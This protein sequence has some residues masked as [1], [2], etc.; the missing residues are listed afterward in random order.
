M[1]NQDP[2][3]VKAAMDAAAKDA[4]KELKKL[5]KEAVKAVS[6]W[7]NAN[8]VKAAMDA[9]A[10]D[11]AA[12]D[13]EKE[14]KKLPKEAVKAVAT[15]MNANFVKAGYKRLSRLLVATV[16]ESKPAKTED[17]ES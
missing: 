9:A 15:W 7:M 4:E 3:A 6:T 13:A 1:A 8:F 11:A 17:K 5:P 14:L 2:E 16:R 12:K 10:M